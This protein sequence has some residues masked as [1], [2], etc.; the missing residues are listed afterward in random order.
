M[1]VYYIYIY[2]ILD[3]W[4]SSYPN[5]YRFSSAIEKGEHFIGII[6]LPIVGNACEHAAAVRF[7]MQEI[8]PGVGRMGGMGCEKKAIHRMNYYDHSHDKNKN[9]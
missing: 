2:C 8:I 5:F 4:F 9:W 7:A 1:Y 6:L 3:W